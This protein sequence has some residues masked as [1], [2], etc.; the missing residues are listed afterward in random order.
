MSTVTAEEGK[1]PTL[2]RYF[3]KRTVDEIS[4]GDVL[5]FRTARK[6][7]GRKNRT[8][9][10]D[11]TLLRTM[12]RFSVVKGYS[13]SNPATEVKNLPQSVADHPLLSTVQYE[14]FLEECWK[15]RTGAQLV[16]W[17]KLRALTGLRPTESLFLEWDD[18]NFQD[19]Q[20]FVRSKVGS[21][22]KGG[23][24][25]VVEIH[26]TL[27]PLIV[28]WRRHWVEKMAPI[29]TP[30]QWVFFHPRYP[31]K[32]ARSFKKSFENAREKAGVPQFRPYDLRHYFI[33][34]AIMSGVDTFTISKWS[35]HASTRMIE[36]VYG[37]LTPEFRAK[38]MGKIKFDLG[39]NGVGESAE[40]PA[41]EAVAKPVPQ[42]T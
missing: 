41:V 36:Q 19:D 3:G 31:E 10:L 33:S 38:Q 12:F 21:P 14:Q 35:G 16:F 28:E 5:A 2:I 30:H 32:Q 42:P 22:L 4:A 37:H 6:K 23:K 29:G 34:M 9:N 15:T 1:M 25:R 39:G 18:I 7:E 11:L 13:A 40:Q 17:I 20:I 8:I 27:K 24:F 26:P